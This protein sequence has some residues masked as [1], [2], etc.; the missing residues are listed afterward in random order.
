M[1]EIIDING[2]LFSIQFI[3]KLFFFGMPHDY[4][5]IHQHES[6]SESDNASNHDPIVK[7]EENIINCTNNLKKEIVNLKDL[8]IKRLQDENEKLRTKCIIWENKVVALEQNLNS[9]GYYGR[10]NN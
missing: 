5:T 8:V 7:L 1:A 3:L 6:V 9:L 10:T 4:N 2:L